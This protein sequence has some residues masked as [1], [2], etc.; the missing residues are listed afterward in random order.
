MVAEGVDVLMVTVCVEEYVP[1]AG[2]KDGRGNGLSVMVYAAE[3]AALA[4]PPE[5]SA[6][7]LTVSEAE[8]EI[9]PE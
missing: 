9:G 3:L 8:T 5:A 1:A 2:L 4:E 7:A 6:I